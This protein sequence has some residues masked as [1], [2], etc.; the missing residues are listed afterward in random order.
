MALTESQLESAFHTELI[1]ELG[2]L[3]PGSLVLK[4]DANYIQGIPDLL[5]LW[6]PSWAA[7]EVKA[8]ASARHRPNQ[9]YYVEM[10]ETSPWIHQPFEIYDDMRPDALAK[11]FSV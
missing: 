5:V 10:L 6:G 3:F 8:S 2:R 7:L 4:N 1:Q 11:K 9:D